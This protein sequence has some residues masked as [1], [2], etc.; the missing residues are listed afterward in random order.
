MMDSPTAL[1][2]I[3]TTDRINQNIV[4]YTGKL[5]IKTTVNNQAIEILGRGKIIYKWFP[6]PKLQ[7]EFVS[8]S[9]SAPL[10]M[11]AL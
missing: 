5:E 9:S 11:V 8:Q 4:L 6:S 1:E 3:Y 2:P 10:L 7:F